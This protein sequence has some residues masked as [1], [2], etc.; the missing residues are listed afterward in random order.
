MNY[1]ND[2]LKSDIIENVFFYHHDLKNFGGGE[3]NI[4]IRL[5]R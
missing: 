3:T 4:K 5:K 1:K 2:V